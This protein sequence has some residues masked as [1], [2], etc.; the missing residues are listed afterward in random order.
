[1]GDRYERTS[2]HLRSAALALVRGRGSRAFSVEALS[3]AADV[4][5]G[6]IYERWDNRVGIL[7]DVIGSRIVDRLRRLG[8]E[9]DT[10]S[11]PERFRNLFD[12]DDGREC[13]AFASDVLF[14]VRDIPDLGHH[15]N[16]IVALVRALV[17]YDEVV[18]EVEPLAWWLTALAIGW[19]IL[20]TGEVGLPPIAD[21]VIFAL[22]GSGQ[23]SDADDSRAMP[24]EIRPTTE[25]SVVDDDVSAA[26]VEVAREMLSSEDGSAFTAREIGRRAGVSKG[27]LYRRYGSRAD[28]IRKVLLNDMDEERFAW[29][30]EFLEVVSGDDPVNGA[31]SAM[32]R[33]LRRVYEDEP[34]MRRLLEV[35]VAARTDDSI[36]AQVLGHVRAAVDERRVVITGLQEAGVL[37]SGVSAEALSWFIQAVPIGTRLMAATGFPPEDK[38]V[39]EAFRMILENCVESPKLSVEGNR[40]AQT[41]VQAPIV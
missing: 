38:T 8:V 6:T 11:S 36:K 20:H 3:R 26:I 1:M 5:V 9:A 32:G 31:A 15:A 14:A 37:K 23:P 27:T 24:G 29:S 18:H 40:P 22:T 39:V 7:D 16:E 34:T 41:D 35:T 30:K 4:G 21:A 33:T 13:L 28:V 25:V 19:G 2:E 12:S 17:D 10:L